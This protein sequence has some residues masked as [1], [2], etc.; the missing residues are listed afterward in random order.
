[1]RT[2]FSAVSLVSLPA[3]SCSS[4]LLSIIVPLPIL[5]PTPPHPPSS[6]SRRYAVNDL[7]LVTLARPESHY[8][9]P[10]CVTLLHSERTCVYAVCTP[11]CCPF[12]WRRR[13]GT[14]THTA[15][16]LSGKF[17]PA[18][19]S[20]PRLTFQNDSFILQF[21]PPKLLIPYTGVFETF[22]SGN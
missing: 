13:C 2:R 10:S 18:T 16:T 15:V 1:M 12:H 6:L 3:S 17:S 14:H 11:R 20:T 9:H 4:Y 22:P 8:W 21:S 5:T 19:P 7:N